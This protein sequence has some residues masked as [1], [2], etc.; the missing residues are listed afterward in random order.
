MSATLISVIEAV[1]S[2]NVHERFGL[3]EHVQVEGQGLRP[4]KWVGGAD[5]KYVLEDFHHSFSYVRFTQDIRTQTVKDLFKGCGDGQRR[6]YGVRVVV[7]AQR[8]DDLCSSLGDIL[9]NI[10]DNVIANKSTLASALGADIIEVSSSQVNLDTYRAVQSEAPGMDWKLQWV[11]NYVD[12]TVEAKG[13]VGCF[14]NCGEPYVIPTG[15]TATV[16]NSSSSY[17]QQVDCGTVFTLPDITHTDS[18]G[19]PAI[20]PAMVPF[21]ATLCSVGSDDYW[22]TIA[23]GG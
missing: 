12:F 17:T 6:T 16:N 9:Q 14:E 3:V 5:M 18:N 2:L 21:V 4:M 23:I 13:E 7:V 8:T 1:A 19:A 11:M 10:P 20:R 15:S 22:R